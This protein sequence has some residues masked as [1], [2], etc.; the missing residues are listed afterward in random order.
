MLSRRDFLGGASALALTPLIERILDHHEHLEEP[1]LFRPPEPKRVFYMHRDLYTGH[2]FRIV[3]DALPFPRRL[4][5]HSVIEHSFGPGSFKRLTQRDHW[6]LIDEGRFSRDQTIQPCVGDG[7]YGA[8]AANYAPESEAV[9]LLEDVG[10]GPEPLDGDICGLSFVNC[11]DD[12]EGAPEVYCDTT[13]AISLLQAEL[14]QRGAPI[15]V[16]FKERDFPEVNWQDFLRNGG[17]PN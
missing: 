15:E 14:L 16:R 11:S 9:R 4:V 8:W 5:E 3:T 12:A 7:F 17:N 2:G 6:R 10:L 1:L 13:R